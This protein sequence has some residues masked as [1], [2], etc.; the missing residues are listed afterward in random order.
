MATVHNKISNMDSNINSLQN[1]TKNIVVELNEVKQMQ[2]KQ[3]L[4]HE[5]AL[6]RQKIARVAREKQIRRQKKYFVQ[7]VI[8]GRAWL[9][10]SDGSAITVTIGDKVLGYGKVASIDP[11]SGLVKMS[12]GIQLHY[13]VR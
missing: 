11:Y 5:A 2:H 4:A 12:T 7:A 3:Q 6:R 9:R 1:T 13:G 10:G 8:P